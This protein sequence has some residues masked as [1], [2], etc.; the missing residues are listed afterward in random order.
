M[1]R[2]TDWHNLDL[3]GDPTPGD[4]YEITAQGR[5]FQ[6]FAEDIATAQGLLN[7]A[8]KDHALTEWNGKAA[9][10]FRGQIGRLPGQLAKLHDSYGAAGDA[11]IAFAR[12]VELE[13][14]AAD[15]A[16]SQ[17]RILR[18]DL[19]SKQA[20]LGR[21]K[22][23]AATAT[24]ARSKLDHPPAAG[25]VPPPDPEKVR[26]A[27]RNVQQAGAH[28]NQVAG[29]VAGIQAQ[30]AELRTK[31]T[32]ARDN[33]GTAVDT[34]RAKLGEASNAGIHNKGFWDKLAEA[35]AWSWD[36]LITV[37][38]WVV[39]IGGI[40]LLFVGGP[41]ALIV[42]VA[43][44]LILADTIVKFARGKAGWGDLLFA[45]LDC[46]PM[47]GKLAMLAKA[48]EIGKEL[49]LALKVAR[50]ER[51]FAGVI[52]VWRMG[53][54][55]KGFQKI[56]F[57][58]AKGMGK[59][60]LKDVMNGGWDKLRQNF[61]QNLTGNVIGAGTGPLIDKGFSKIPRLVYRMPVSEMSSATRRRFGD[62]T[63]AMNGRVEPGKSVI[64]ATRGLVTS[65]TK[66]AVGAVFF[67]DTFDVQAV[68]IGTATG[69]GG[70]GVGYK[71]GLLPAAKY[72]RP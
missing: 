15:G 47:V 25:N 17:A 8:A 35:A 22:S 33:H 61:L 30:L 20:E 68:G 56:G 21:A 52:K 62:L 60:S 37:S 18:G 14:S 9:E 41:L 7:N 29:Q 3:D 10:A 32:R 11:L 48:G 49:G 5:R 42:L 4:V 64:G 24:A 16:L 69:V 19:A 59:D 72:A 6:T 12:A 57:A 71:P 23:A 2:P 54:D 13:Q 45:A 53:E 1:A 66:Q 39:A 36:F 31:A 46:V 65:V 51:R 67:G 70:S 43:A 38:K 27:T 26:Q 34:L 63:M 28:Q 40:V 55:L 58:F 44:L 50:A